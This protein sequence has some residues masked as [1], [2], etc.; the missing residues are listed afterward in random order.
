[1]KR[2]EGSVILTNDLYGLILMGGKSSRMGTDKSELNYHGKPHVEFMYELASSLVSKAF[3]SVKD[4]SAKPNFTDLFISDSY[5]LGG[6]INGILSAMTQFPDKAWLVLAVDMPFVNE[7]TIRQLLESRNKE[8]IATAFATR[9][10][11]LPEPLAAIWEPG[12]RELLRQHYLVEDK[13]C[14]RGFLMEKDIELVYPKNDL[15]L[16]NANNPDEYEH[17]KSLIK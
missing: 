12:S 14:P 2:K 8:K 16:Y 11:G 5:E 4:E 13:K 7:L 10:S 6:P 1:M 3:V 17:A 9:E 15:E